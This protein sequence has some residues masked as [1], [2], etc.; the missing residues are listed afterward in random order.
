MSFKNK[1]QRKVTMS[2]PRP[3]RKSVGMMVLN[4]ANQVF[5][6][7][8]VDYPNGAWQMPQGGM[9]TGESPRE[10]ALRELEEETGMT[11]VE[12]ITESKTWRSYDVPYDLSQKLWGGE[13]R[14]QT[15]KWFLMRF[16]GSDHEIKL[17]NHTAEFCE[18][19]WA[20]LDEITELAV[21]FKRK[22]YVE[23]VREF[24]EILK[25]SGR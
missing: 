14:G 25:S 20:N 3:Y 1:I 4:E 13:Y 18:W 2:D 24:A 19:R 16:F 17:D 15:Q 11:S 22:T 6:A 5:I 7:R 23:I 9:D 21:Y 8:R 12:I 10:S